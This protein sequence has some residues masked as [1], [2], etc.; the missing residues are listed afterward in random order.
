[1]SSGRQVLASGE[2]RKPQAVVQNSIVPMP[3]ISAPLSARTLRIEIIRSCLRIV[4]APST[5]NSSAIEPVRR[6]FL[7]K[8]FEMHGFRFYWREIG[9]G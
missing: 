6:A 9:T 7:L 5:P 3:M 2:R 4:D 1:M 8:V